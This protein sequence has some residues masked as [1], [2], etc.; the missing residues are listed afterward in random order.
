[1]ISSS[2]S[3]ARLVALV[4]A[5]GIGARAAVPGSGPLPKQY[6]LIAGQPLLWHTVH[7]LL[8]D[9]RIDEVRVAVAA[10]DT[11][12]ARVLRGL[13]RTVI[14][15]CGGATRAETVLKALQDA[16]LDRHDWV[17]VHDAARPGL[18]AD[19]LARLI[20]A[21]H[22]HP[23]GGLLAL[24]M[25][26]TIKKASALA[27]AR[28]KSAHHAGDNR[29][30]ADCVEMTVSRTGLWAAQTP[31]MFRAQA[32]GAALE[33]AL[34]LG[35]EITDEASAIEATGAK[36]LLVRGSSRNAKVTWPEDFEW[37]GSWL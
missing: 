29:V 20:D 10:G 14:R 35:F 33:S 34:A 13:P 17:L 27:E 32:L 9:P 22:N 18:P 37:V 31:Q 26:D 4:P 30:P 28:E 2:A 5:A 3:V 19:A 24:P 21:C 6:R 36:P 16:R 11:D 8:R 25:A 7:A 15:P 12:A 1:V 23:T